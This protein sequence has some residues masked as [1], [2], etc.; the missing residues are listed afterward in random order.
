MNATQ[1][2]YLTEQAAATERQAEWLDG[3]A[4]QAEHDAAHWREAEA[5]ARTEAAELRE[6]LD[7]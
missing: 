7:Q 4:A 1:R 3:L 6:G 5:G 2:R